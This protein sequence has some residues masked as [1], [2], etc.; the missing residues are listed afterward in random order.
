MRAPVQLRSVRRKLFVGVLLTSVVALPITGASLLA[1]DLH[2]LRTTLTD[3]LTTQA[4]L[5]GH[6]CV[7]ALQ[8]DDAKVASD[9]LALLQARPMIDAAALYSAKGAIFGRYIRSG[10]ATQ[11]FPQ[12]PD[13]DGVRFS[14]EDIFVERRI[15]DNGEIVGSIYL[16]AH[17]NLY[18]RVRNYTGIVLL[19]S[20]FALLIS[21]L[22]ST[23]LQ[24]TVTRPI[25]AITQ[26][27][28]HVIEKDDHSLRAPKSTDDEIGYLADAFNGMLA[29]VGARTDELEA[30]NRELGRE[31][32]ERQRAED[33]RRRLN[34]E[35]EARVEERTQKLQETNKELEAFSYSI[36][37]DL[38][39]P[40]RAIDGFAQLLGNRYA[41]ALDGEGMRL[42]GVVRD[43]SRRM[44]VLIDDLLAFSRLGRKPAT[45]E[46]TDMG[47]LVSE[48]LAEVL[49]DAR[50]K[51][52]V[53]VGT[54]PAAQCDRALLKQVWL[55][56]IGNAV[57]YSSHKP[58]P[59]IEI[60]ALD[61]THDHIYT[62]RD[63]GA[64]FDMRYYEKLF[65]VFQRLHSSEEFSGTGVGLAIVQ[66]IILK[67][68]G[69]VWAE[70]V[71]DQGAA[72]HFT[73]PRTE[74]SA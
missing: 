36:S 57:K 71:P 74:T 60:T 23:W 44:G 14:G 70:A 2:S 13:D 4:D 38:R 32:A 61:D 10:A 59:R 55:N 35:L 16:H 50:S 72:F 20:S 51:P 37:H 43:S 48:C 73:L 34:A 52:E 45:V 30:S 25:L 26:L 12:L 68:G 69:R 28:R 24:A 29:K 7:P 67:H 21:L 54:L 40:L 22:L 66:R 17:Y 19:V 56:L 64:G 6:A 46:P 33:E 1:Y 47:R 11:G 27:A 5:I 42:L 62:V 58:A 41:A 31:V 53:L 39:A 3:D 8:F 15:V 49:G 65:G 18:Q 63:N 9:N